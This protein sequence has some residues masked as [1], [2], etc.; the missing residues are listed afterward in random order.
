MVWADVDNNPVVAFVEEKYNSLN[1]ESFVHMQIEHYF[2]ILLVELYQYLH[3][4]YGRL[5]I[6]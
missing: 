1:F 3:C 6:T 4:R 5:V 2:G